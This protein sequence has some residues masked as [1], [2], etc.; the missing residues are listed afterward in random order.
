MKEYFLF[1]KKNGYLI[2]AGCSWLFIIYEIWQWGL[3]EAVKFLCSATLGL[4]LILAIFHVLSSKF[5]NRVLHAFLPLFALLLV[6]IWL[7]F[8]YAI[9]IFLAATE[10]IKNPWKYNG[11]VR[12]CR[13]ADKALFGHFPDKIP[14]D[15]S[16]VRFHYVPRFLQGGGHLQVRYSL[17]SEEIAKLYREF[18]KRK[19]VSLSGGDINSSINDE[20]AMPAT[21]FYTGDDK[22]E[23]FPKDYEIMIFDQF[24]PKGKRS[25]NHGR[26]HGVAISKKKNEIVYWAEL[27]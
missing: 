3:P 12:E 24:V 1:I 2:T 17:P 21:N 22:S 20:K 14:S 26:A 10:G 4:T 5:R 23:I 11:I 18:E 9:T 8:I 6:V 16:N 19:T 7:G 15:A 27:W 25:W 13:K